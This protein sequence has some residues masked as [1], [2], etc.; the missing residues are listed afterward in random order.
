MELTDVLAVLAAT[1]GVGMGASP[2][3]QARRA[4]HR[5][6]SQDVSVTFLAVLFCGGLVWMSYGLALGN[7][8]LIVANAV[9]VVGSGTACLV[10]LRYR[11]EATPVA[12]D[13]AG[14]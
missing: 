14:T 10:A 6:S 4:H 13:L 11:D 5:R 2:L 7:T 3:L 9:G 12:D 8:A 1:F